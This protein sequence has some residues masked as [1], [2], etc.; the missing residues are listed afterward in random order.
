MVVF[1]ADSKELL[2]K[3]VTLVELKLGRRISKFSN[4]LKSGSSWLQKKKGRH[5]V[6]EIH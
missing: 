4:I 1:A 2:K 5:V 6:F 3:T